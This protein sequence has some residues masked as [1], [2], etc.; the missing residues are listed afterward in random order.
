MSEPPRP[1]ARRRT[2]TAVA[3]LVVMLLGLPLVVWGAIG[4]LRST[5]NDPRQ[6]LPRGFAE[7]DR[8]DW[9]QEHFGSDEIAVVSW[10]GCTLDDP[11]VDQLATALTVSPYF[12]RVRSGPSVLQQ[13]MQ[14]PLELSRPAAL[15]RLRGSLLGSHGQDTCLVL[16]TSAVG[17]DDRIAAVGEIERLAAA[18]I[19]VSADSLRLAGPTV[20]AA[21]IDAE[22]RRLLFQLAGFAALLSFVIAS[23]RLRSVPMAIMVLLVAG[24]STGL[25]LAILYF[26]GG[27][28]N[29]LMTMLPPLIYVLSISSAVH[30]A[31]YYRDAV[32]EPTPRDKRGPGTTP[33]ATAVAHGWLPCSLAAVT[34]GIGLASLVLS[35]IDPIRTF[36]IYAA[37][38]IVASV[39]VLFLFLPAALYLFPV[40]QTAAPAKSAKRLSGSN[41][42]AGI[43]RYHYVVLAGCLVVMGLGAWG[44]P[45]VKSTVRLQDRFLPSSDAIQDYRWLEQHVGPMVPLEVVIHF[46]K[47][48]SQDLLQRL[49]TVAMV[50]GEIQSMDQPL[51][52][53]SAINLAP[54]LPRG[55][56][57]ADVAK[58]QVINRESTYQGLL[59]TDF[60]AET[61]DEQLWRITVRAE[62]IGDLDYGRF[63]ETLRQNIDP[64]LQQQRA[65]GTYTGVIPLIYKAQRQLLQDLFRSFLAAFAVIAVVL[66]LVLRS[67]LAAALA[68][69]PNLFPA[70]VVFGGLEWVDIPIQI[71][72]VM[73]ASA[74]LGIAVDDTVHFLTWFR[75]GIDAGASR[76]AALRDAFERCAGAM[77]HTT[78]ICCGGL[79]VFAASSFV[80]ILHF[81]WLMVFLLL[82]ALVGDLLLLP[83]ILAGPLGR[84]FER[85]PVR[86]KLERLETVPAG[87]GG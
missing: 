51:A 53:M 2:R 49:R 42:I 82:A 47:H 70:V 87:E 69:V 20:D 8:Y 56:G 58:R 64:L 35:K 85:R 6:W 77:L 52:T 67:P 17:Q 11:R 78:L 18:R 71:G 16:S 66:V 86:R 24:Y 44:L 27:E 31:N 28:M 84:G 30:L 76:Q 48:D 57:I 25:G 75:R 43:A 79:L 1:A 4:A 45:Y 5:S 37:I 32:A 59:A 80:P 36:G 39:G 81:A 12:D 50:Q 61:E 55:G 60:V 65:R 22:S 73:T 23:V 14:P 74:A 54:R 7:T 3:T 40:R 34:T 10:P 38:G 83:A 72:S 9:F 26:S 21:A 68:M 33:L 19:D 62:A 46:D 41:F 13:L 29:L 15:R 63:A